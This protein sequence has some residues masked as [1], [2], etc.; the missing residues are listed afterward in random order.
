MVVDSTRPLKST[1]SHYFVQEL[2]EK[3]PLD[4]LNLFF[5]LFWLLNAFYFWTWFITYHRQSQSASRLK[6]IETDQTQIKSQQILKWTT[7]D[8]PQILNRLWPVNEWLAKT[9]EKWSAVAKVRWHKQT[10]ACTT[11]SNSDWDATR[12]SFVT[13]LRWICTR[14]VCLDLYPDQKI[15]QIRTHNET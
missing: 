11:I 14:Q 2:L 13:F 8:W 1:F 15:S 6:K 5:Q 7:G 10:K 3:F 4:K 9:G 12:L